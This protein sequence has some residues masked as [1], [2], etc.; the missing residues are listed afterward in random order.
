MWYAVYTKPR[1]EKKVRDRLEEKGIVN[2]LPLVK[3]LRQWADRKKWVEIPL[4]SNYIFVNIELKD[5]LR[6]LTTEGVVRIVAFQG[7]P[8]PIPDW[9]IESLMK[10]VDGGEEIESA[11]YFQSNDFVE[12]IEGPFKGVK[13]FVLDQ[14]SRNRIAI[15]ITGIYQSVVITVRPDWLK[16][17]ESSPEI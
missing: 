12:V 10:I 3:R 7:K 1:H 4:F 5:S 9:Q 11:P 13:G 8:V 17:I 16:K 2:Y 14:K 15:S 6:V